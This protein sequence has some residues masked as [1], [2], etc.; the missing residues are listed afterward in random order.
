[1]MDLQILLND[2]PLTQLLPG[3]TSISLRHLV[4]FLAGLVD[5]HNFI[6]TFIKGQNP[7]E[8]IHFLDYFQKLQ[9]M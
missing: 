1:M 8:F 5:L 7:I 4:V 9:L 3:A 6:L 2:G